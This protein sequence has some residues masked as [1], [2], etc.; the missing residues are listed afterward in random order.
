MKVKK[1]VIDSSDLPV[2]LFDGNCHLCSR[3]VKWILRVDRVG[4]F[5]FASL[6]SAVGRSLL[7]DLA[8]QHLPPDSIVLVREQRIYLRSDAVLEIASGLG[9]PW[10]LLTVF[11]WLLP[12]A[13]L[14][15]IYDWIARNRY[16]WFG[17]SSTCWM[18]DARWQG[19]FL[20]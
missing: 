18:P 20:G 1:D 11:R 10:S 9:L 14:D 16:R 15:K 8:G 7:K 2:V 3:A 4:R 6:H 12:G 19:R 13:L 17:R 5:R